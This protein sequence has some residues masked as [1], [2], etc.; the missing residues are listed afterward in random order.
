MIALIRASRELVEDAQGLEETLNNAFARALALKLDLAALRGTGTAPEPRGLF[1]TTGVNEVSMGTNGAQLTNWDKI[2]DA[3][4]AVRDDNHEPNGALVLAP[5]TAA[6]I[7][8]MKDTTNQ[9]LRRPP[10]LEDAQILSTTQVGIADTQG[11][12]TNA[13]AIYL[14]DWPQL[15][16]GMRTNLTIEVLRERYSDNHQMGFVAAL[17]ADVQ[18]AHPE[19]FARIVEI[20]P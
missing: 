4:Q 5:R 17:R 6:T 16:I 3:Y 18:L 9:P 20:I 15:M 19:A 11:T 7:A 12:A 10:D 8:K 13:S 14:G 1:N 2:V